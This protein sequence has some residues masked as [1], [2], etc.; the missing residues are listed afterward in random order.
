[1]QNIQYDLEFGL[2]LPPEIQ[3]KRMRRVMDNELTTTQRH[4]LELYYFQ[5]MSVSQ[6]A[7]SRGVHVS[8]VLRSIRRAKDRLR[9]CLRY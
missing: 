5:G 3:L 7:R 9:R 1:M 4:D 2:E 8:T 6:I